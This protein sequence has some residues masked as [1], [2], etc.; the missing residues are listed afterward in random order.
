[1]LIS[2]YIISNVY[3][4]HAH[5]PRYVFS[6]LEYR[7]D[8]GQSRVHTSHGSCQFAGLI[9]TVGTCISQFVFKWS[10][11]SVGRASC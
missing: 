1:M 7:A 10:I 3:I 11:S 4:V 6:W 9:A 5:P 8:N 2:I